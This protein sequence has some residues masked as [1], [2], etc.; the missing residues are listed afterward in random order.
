MLKN[1]RNNFQNIK[2][3]DSSADTTSGTTPYV[4]PCPG[5]VAEYNKYDEEVKN[6]EDRIKEFDDA[7]AALKTKSED[8]TKLI[9]DYTGIQE[10]LNNA[11]R[12]KA[13]IEGYD[14]LGDDMLCLSKFGTAILTVSQELTSH[15]DAWDLKKQEAER[16]RSTA[17]S[18]CSSHGCSY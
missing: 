12:G 16:N 1:I 4:D 7:L 14:T 3:E 17:A 2:R 15:R 8:S 18:N 11:W 9:N 6:C 10:D 13:D 5:L